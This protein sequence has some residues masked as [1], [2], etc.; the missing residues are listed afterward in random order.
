MGK[1]LVTWKGVTKEIEAKSE[2]DAQ[3]RAT[4]IFATHTTSDSPSLIRVVKSFNY[5]TDKSREKSN[6]KA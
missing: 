5:E 6:E 4:H 3:V 2:F 1:Y